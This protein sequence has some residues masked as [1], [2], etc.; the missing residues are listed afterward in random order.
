MF[1]SAVEFVVLTENRSPIPPNKH[2][3]LLT[4]RNQDRA[5]MGRTLLL[6]AGRVKKEGML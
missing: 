5:H 6:M 4:G 3:L 2:Q 1:S